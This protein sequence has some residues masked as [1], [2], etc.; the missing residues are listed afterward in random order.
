MSSWVSLCFT[1]NKVNTY[2]WFKKHIDNLEQ[3]PDWR[4]SIKMGG[5]RSR[6]RG[7]R[8]FE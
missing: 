7:R 5:R 1:F 2:D 4:S 6:K 3:F 8:L